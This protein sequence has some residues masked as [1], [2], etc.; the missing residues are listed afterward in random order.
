MHVLALTA[1][2]TD[3]ARESGTSGVCDT[4]EHPTRL[5][6]AGMYIISVTASKGVTSK[7]ILGVSR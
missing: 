7:A 5:D 2:Y 3:A 4:V 6:I 1:D